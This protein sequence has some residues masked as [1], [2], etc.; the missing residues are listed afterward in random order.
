M[1]IFIEFAFLLVVCEFLIVRSSGNLGCTRTAIVIVAIYRLIYGLL[2]FGVLFAQLNPMISF[3]IMTFGFIAIVY[4]AKGLREL[5][6]V[7]LAMA[8]YGGLRYKINTLYS[9]DPNYVLLCALILLVSLLSFLVVR[10]LF[11]RLKNKTRYNERK[12]L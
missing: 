3:V 10:T 7:V 6:F 11:S 2:V 1:A 4:Y 9:S 12:N 8:V 5:V